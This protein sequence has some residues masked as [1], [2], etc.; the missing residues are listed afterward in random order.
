MSDELLETLRNPWVIVGLAGQLIF[1]LRFVVQWIQSERAGRSIVPEVFWYLSIVG[2]A[3]LL[4]YSLHRRDLVFILGQSAGFL[5]YAR[6]IALR[7][8][9]IA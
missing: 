6:N 5:V 9:E 7:R 1:S 2:S 8:R 4:V 3:L